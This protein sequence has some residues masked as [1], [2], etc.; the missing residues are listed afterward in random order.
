MVVTCAMVET[1]YGAWSSWWTSGCWANKSLLVYGLM[2]LPQCGGYR[3]PYKYSLYIY[4]DIWYIYIYI[5]WLLT[6]ANVTKG[7]AIIR[8]RNYSLPKQVSEHKIDRTVFLFCC[9]S[10]CWNDYNRPTHPIITYYKPCWVTSMSFIPHGLQQS[11][12]W[13]DSSG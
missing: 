2:T 10:P 4:T 12:R 8:L 13:W 11:Q 9:Y 5:F 6:M 1:W 3:Y 7:Y